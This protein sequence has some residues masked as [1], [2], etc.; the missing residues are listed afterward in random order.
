MG[1]K[2]TISGARFAYVHVWEKY[3]FENAEA[4]Y[5]VNILIPKS[6]KTT[7]A[8]IEDAISKEMKTGKHNMW[9][10]KIPKKLYYP[11]RDGD[12]DA[13]PSSGDEYAGHYFVVAKSKKRRPL[14]L[15]EDKEL[16][17]D[18]DTI[19]SGCYGKAV[20]Q[21]FA[22]ANKGGMGVGAGLCGLQ[23][24]SDGEPLGGSIATESD[25][26]DVDESDADEDEL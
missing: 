21:F 12:E 24:T 18:E 23:K 3:Q 17:R 25:F 8:K 1:D 14:L 15:D 6:S 2:V 26:D 10:G 20:I 22:Y 11:L 19:Y 4:Q 16:V 13:P 9:D 5:S 7:I